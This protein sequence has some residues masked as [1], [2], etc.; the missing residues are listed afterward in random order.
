MTRTALRENPPEV[1]VKPGQHVLTAEPGGA[2]Q[3]LDGST[4]AVDLG[5]SAQYF[6]LQAEAPPDANGGARMKKDRNAA[7]TAVTGDSE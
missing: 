3:N 4:R 7:R 5:S 6:P 2:V 1:Q